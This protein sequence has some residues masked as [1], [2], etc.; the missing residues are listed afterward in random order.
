M[1]FCGLS[2]AASYCAGSPAC[3]LLNTIV[4]TAASV[5]GRLLV[6]LRPLISLL[7]DPLELRAARAARKAAGAGWLFGEQV[8]GD[9]GEEASGGQRGQGDDER[10]PVCAD[11]GDGLLGAAVEGCVLT[12]VAHQRPAAGGKNHERHGDEQDPEAEVRAGGVPGDDALGGA[13]GF[14]LQWLQIA[15]EKRRHEES[16]GEDERKF[17][18]GDGAADWLHGM[19]VARTGA[20]GKGFRADAADL[21]R[22]GE[23]VTSFLHCIRSGLTLRSR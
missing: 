17:H 20:R 21:L 9:D 11:D 7:L 15:H 4:L 8:Q 12:P 3:F 10:G 1:A 18:G 6:S 13:G 14:V 16:R 2:S 19:V 22:R 23:T 5:R